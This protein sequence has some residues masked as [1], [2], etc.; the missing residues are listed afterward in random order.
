MIRMLPFLLITL[1]FSQIGFT[2]DLT[3]ILESSF[4]KL[5]CLLCTRSLHLGRITPPAQSSLYSIAPGNSN[6]KHVFP[7]FQRF[8][9]FLPEGLPA[10]PVQIPFSKT[11]RPKL[12]ICKN[13][14]RVVSTCNW[15]SLVSY[16]SCFLLC[17]LN[18]LQLRKIPFPLH[19]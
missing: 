7:V 10:V 19:K 3:F 1:H 12:L 13:F 17:H 5:G 9:V 6:C 15:K 18:F 14:G 8:S 11:T 4:L 2:E 16:A